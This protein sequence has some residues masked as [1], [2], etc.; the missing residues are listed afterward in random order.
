VAV[1]C[2]SMA[3]ASTG[4]ATGCVTA[5]VDGAVLDSDTI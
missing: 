5:C 4:C 1:G 2:S 3:L